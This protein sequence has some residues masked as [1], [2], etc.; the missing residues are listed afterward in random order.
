MKNESRKLKIL[1]NHGGQLASPTWRDVTTYL[2]PNGQDLLSSFKLAWTLYCQRSSFDC[3]VLGGGTSDYLF[4]LLQTLLP[5]RTVPCVKIDCLW[6]KSTNR[7]RYLF[8]RAILR[9]TSKSVDRFI[10]WAR[11]DI[12]AFSET[13]HIPQEKFLFVPYHTTLDSVNPTPHSGGYVFSGGNEGRDYET[14]LLAVQG[15]PLKLLIASTSPGLFSHM[16][17]PENVEIKGFSHEEY[18]QKMAE[19]LINIVP[20]ESGGLRTGGHQ[21]YLNSMWLGKP[22]IVNDPEG[23]CDYIKHMEDG[24]LVAP[25]DP[26]ALR[27][28]IEFLL[29]RRDVMDEMAV[30]AAQKAKHYSTE[31]HFRKIISVVRQILEQKTINDPMD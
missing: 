16:S 27:A 12:K 15:L 11:R 26:K 10:V 18:L 20:L 23:A 5:F 30:R 22:T 25:K 29:S 31:E 21:T 3:V 2:P 13:F 17:I 9:I 1:T 14:L 6:T 24:F 28:A 4:A 7:L 8:H 19:C